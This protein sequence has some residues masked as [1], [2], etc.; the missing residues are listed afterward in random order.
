M[1]S[2][3][4]RT[5]SLQQTSRARRCTAV[6][7]EKAKEHA[8]KI[9]VLALAG[10]VVLSSSGALAQDPGTIVFSTH[11]IDPATPTDLSENFVAGDAIYALAYLEKALPAYTNRM[12]SS[13][14]LTEVFLYELKPPLYDYQDPSEAQLDFGSLTVS[15]GAL[16]KQH[17]VIDI[18]PDPGAMTAYGHPD[19]S[20]KKYGDTFDG[21]MKF[22]AVLSQLE[23]GDHTIVVKIKC[24]YNVVAEG[25]FTLSGEDFGALASAS[26][27]IGAVAH[28]LKIKDTVMPTARL[29]DPVLEA[30][31][32]AA[33][34]ASQTY[35]DRIKGEVQRLVIIDPDWMI[36]RNELTGVI[37][38]R[39]IRAAVAVKNADGSCTLWNLMT[40]QQDYV[41]DA[42]QKTR[43]DGVGDPV[44]I[45]CEKVMH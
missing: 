17:L 29:S 10:L 36:R 1:A 30:E 42:F 28:G 27:A 26:S 6:A 37:L 5:A 32:I 45:P 7:T 4:R 21:P 34:E 22:A 16:A 19:Y 20:Y 23:P 33:L 11:T 24:N 13:K 25:S 38:H 2:P 9:G 35:R 8:M 18:V 14:V 31:M 12:A 3:P 43:F 41:S 15:G 39:Y 44:P 40:F